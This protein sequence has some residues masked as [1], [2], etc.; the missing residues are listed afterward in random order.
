MKRGIIKRKSTKRSKEGAAAM[1]A[2]KEEHFGKPCWYCELNEATDAHHIAKRRGV[3]YDDPRNLFACCRW[4]HDRA[5]GATIVTRKGIKLPPIPLD[6]ILR[7]KELCDPPLDLPFL[8]M[9]SGPG[10]GRL[11]MNFGEGLE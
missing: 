9:L 7:I 5:E 3:I 1:R 10:D 6:V 4:C 2:F 8:R 11:N